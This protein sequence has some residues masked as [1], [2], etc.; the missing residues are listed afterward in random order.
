MNNY[1][2][3]TYKQ[4]S[5]VLLK[6]WIDKIIS[7]SEYYKIMDKINKCKKEEEEIDRLSEQ[8]GFV[9]EITPFGQEIK[10]MYEK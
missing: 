3:I 6:L 2:R 5:D 1:Q 4:C 9:K 8:F 7:D 10:V